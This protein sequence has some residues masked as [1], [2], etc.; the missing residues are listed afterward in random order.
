MGFGI[1]IEATEYEYTRPSWNRGRETFVI[2]YLFWSR[3]M[4]EQSQGC[5]RVFR[6]YHMSSSYGRGT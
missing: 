1:K 4:K 3:E 2:W 5:S 6:G